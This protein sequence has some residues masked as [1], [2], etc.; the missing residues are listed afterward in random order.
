MLHP[1]ME[2]PLAW[3]FTAASNSSC[4]QR[5][6]SNDILPLMYN[7]ISLKC[8]KFHGILSVAQCRMNTPQ[9]NWNSSLF[10]LL[11]VMH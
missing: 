5:I 8:R 3:T 11:H 7:S 1:G 10:F 2:G 9:E 4:K 6:E